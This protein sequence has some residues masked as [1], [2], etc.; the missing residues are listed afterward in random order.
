MT[1]KS[2]ELKQEEMAKV[3]GGKVKDNGS[4]YEYQTTKPY[5][6][7]CK[8]PIPMVGRYCLKL[9]SFGFLSFTT[10][11]KY[12]R[13]ETTVRMVVRT[14]R[15][16]Y[17]GKCSGYFTKAKIKISTIVATTIDLNAM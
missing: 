17:K 7:D 6:R 14:Q 11:G 10:N 13:F 9:S 15:N 5:C 3:A 16:A 8:M 12:I 2:R 4:K 1:E